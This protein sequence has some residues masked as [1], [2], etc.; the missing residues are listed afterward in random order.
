MKDSDDL[1][2]A[3]VLDDGLGSENALH[4]RFNGVAVDNAVSGLPRAVSKG[5][6]CIHVAIALGSMNAHFD[7]IVA[8]VRAEIEENGG[9]LDLFARAIFDDS[10]CLER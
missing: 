10:S 3:C 2:E 5:R 8:E 9:L 7:G 6:R 4:I 1:R